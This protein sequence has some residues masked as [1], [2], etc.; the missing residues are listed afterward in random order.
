MP[1]PLTVLFLASNPFAA[2]PVNL[3]REAR[4][5]ADSVRQRTSGDAI[6]FTTEWA[7]RRRD[8]Q[9]ALLR[10][11]PAIVHYAGH[12]EEGG[13][14][15]ESEGGAPKRVSTEALREMFS[16]LRPRIRVVVL[17]ACHSWATVETLNGLVDYAVGMDGEIG[18]RS[19]VS[20]ATGFYTALAFGESVDTA[21]QLGV[22]Q[23]RI[24]GLSGTEIPRLL[25]R[26]GA[27]QS[28]L[29]PAVPAALPS[30]APAEGSDDLRGLIQ[31]NDCTVGS[32]SLGGQ[33]GGNTFN[34]SIRM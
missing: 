3:P 23:M 7:V 34:N 25:V 31:L 22:S 14:F 29:A 10:H 26:E 16:A 15:L 18:D 6:E 4:E 8:L 9:P 28:P 11:R 2:R 24:D 1:S 33:G 5:I 30:P 20:F 19:A 13:I 21:F 32:I 27:D 12:G 17:N